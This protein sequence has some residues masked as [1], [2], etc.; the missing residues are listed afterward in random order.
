[1]AAV[2]K[3]AGKSAAVNLAQQ[4]LR[5]A[6]EKAP[7]FVFLGPPGVGKGTYASKMAHQLDLSH[8]GV[9]DLVRREIKAHSELGKMVPLLLPLVLNQ[10][11]ICT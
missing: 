9:G 1:M 8:V 4:I 7:T 3:Q 2:L 10:S 11:L 6:A 5:P